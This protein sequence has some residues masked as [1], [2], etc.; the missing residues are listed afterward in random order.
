MLFPEFFLFQRPDE[1]YLIFCNQRKLKNVRNDF[2]SFAKLLKTNLPEGFRFFAYPMNFA[3]FR[4]SYQSFF[5]CLLPFFIRIYPVS[6]I[7]PQLH[8]LFFLFALPLIFFS[9]NPARK[10]AEGSYL[11]TKTKIHNDNRSISEDELKAI[12]KQQPNRKILGVMRFHLRVYNFANRGKERQWKIWLKSVGEEPVVL[13]SALTEKSSR[14]LNLFL[15]NKG[16]FNSVVSDSTVYLDNKT[17]HVHYFIASGTP[18]T[19]NKITFSIT[20]NNLLKPVKIANN[21]TLIKPGVIYDTDVFSR[22]RERMSDAMKNLGYYNFSKEYIF[23]RMDSTLEGQKVDVKQIIRNPYKKISVNGK[24]SL[25]ESRHSI[26]F[27]NNIYINSNYNPQQKISITEDTVMSDGYCFMGASGI[28]FRPEVLI[29]SIFIKKDDLYGLENVEYTHNRLA[30]LKTFK[31]ISIRFEEIKTEDTLR[32]YLDCYILLT[33]APRQSLTIETEGTHRQGN[34]GV[35]GELVYRN[36]NTFKGAEV[37]ELKFRGGLEVQ[38]LAYD[39]S[40]SVLWDNQVSEQVGKVVPFNTMEISPEANLFFPNLLIPFGIGKILRPGSPKTNIIASYNFQQRLDFSRHI[41]TGSF[42]Y[43][44]KSSAYNSHSFF[45]FDISIVEIDKT[46]AFEDRLDQINNPFLKNS[47]TDHLISASRYTYAFS[48][49]KGKFSN[50]MFFRWNSEVAGNVLRLINKSFNTKPDENGAY[51][52]FNKKEENTDTIIPN[53]GIRY[54]HYLKT[55][56]DLRFYNNINKHSNVVYR[57]FFGIGKPLRNFNVLPFEKSYFGGGANGIRA[58]TARSL[59]PGSSQNTSG[60]TI[61]KIGDIQ[62]EGNVEYRFDLIKILDGAVFMDAGNVW[63]LQKDTTRPNA[64]FDFNRFYNEI[65]LGAGI[66]A[67]LDFN[68]F[69]IRFDTGI[70][71]KDPSEPLGEKNGWVIK[72]FFDDQWKNDYKAIYERKYPFLNFNL[73]IGYPF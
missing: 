54:A 33:P 43:S 9:C 6:R 50:F 45:P 52:L 73:G 24:D 12:L 13:D 2:S 1:F 42:G 30:A 11:L 25:V 26:Y 28:N 35:A 23:F 41:F 32:K 67:R 66:G 38:K 29:K 34:L 64:E 59:G 70:K 48:N 17:A 40:E 47:F 27:I 61:D 49:Q 62:L 21:K 37:L 56:I 15:K 71:V 16:Y 39:T 58:W 8:L 14:Q 63:L 5:Y 44:G 3:K 72:H 68:F 18:Y 7:L 69:I 65:A 57:L 60:L 4:F 31:F 55:D 46:K 51:H 19:V 53:S 22:E 10:I 20:D 36:K